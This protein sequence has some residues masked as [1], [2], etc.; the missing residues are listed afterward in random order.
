MNMVVKATD[1]M[2]ILQSNTKTVFDIISLCLLL[3]QFKII[4]I[5]G[6]SF[7]E[8]SRVR[9]LKPLPNINKKLDPTRGQ[10]GSVGN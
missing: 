5:E 9:F 4:C 10:L 2:S 7:I 8:N 1:Q 3:S 6:M